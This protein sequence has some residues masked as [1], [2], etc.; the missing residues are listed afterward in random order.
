MECLEKELKSKFSA[1]KGTYH[2]V[3]YSDFL[4]FRRL[5]EEIHSCIAWFK[6][7]HHTLVRVVDW[8]KVVFLLYLMQVP[9]RIYLWSRRKKNWS[10]L[11]TQSWS[12]L[13]DLLSDLCALHT[14]CTLR[15]TTHAMVAWL[16]FF[17]LVSNLLQT[18]VML[19]LCCLNLCLI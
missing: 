5:T 6:D 19:G 16:Q 12:V 3:S 1:L 17:Q 8:F 7:R 9:D 15:R 2:V 18:L 4:F 10:H 13:K 11:R 14:E